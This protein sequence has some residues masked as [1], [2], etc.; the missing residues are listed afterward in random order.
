MGGPDRPLSM[1]QD[2]PT[3]NPSFRRS[4]PYLKLASASASSSKT[5]NTNDSFVTTKML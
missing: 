2:V 5:S 1:P 3:G 4:G